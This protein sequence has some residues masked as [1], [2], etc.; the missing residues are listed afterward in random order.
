MKRCMHVCIMHVCMYACMYVCMYIFIYV[1]VPIFMYLCIYVFMYVSM[2][3]ML[4]KNVCRYMNMIVFTGSL[5]W[6]GWLE[7]TL[8]DAKLM[9]EKCENMFMCSLMPKST[10]KSVQYAGWTGEVGQILVLREGSFKEGLELLVPS[11]MVEAALLPPTL[12]LPR[13]EIVE[14]KTIKT[15]RLRRRPMNGR[16]QLGNVNLNTQTLGMSRTRTWKLNV[17]NNLRTL[18]VYPQR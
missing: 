10:A 8:R 18:A 7:G 5:V 11:K 17:R 16:T 6:F 13:L 4:N 14:V 2:N 1:C 3:N 15:I 9:L 12:V